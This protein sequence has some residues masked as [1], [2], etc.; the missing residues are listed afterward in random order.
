MCVCTQ[1]LSHV[2]FFATTWT[3]ACQA[4][5]SMEFS[6]QEYWSGLPFPT[7][8][9]LPDP[10]IEPTSLASPALAGGFFTTEPPGKPAWR[11]TCSQFDPG[12]RI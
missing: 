11:A 3:V 12:G 7:P 10:G 1:L 2:Q 4:P 9:D 8:G 6:R 5:L